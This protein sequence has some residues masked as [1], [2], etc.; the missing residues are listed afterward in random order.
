MILQNP[1]LDSQVDLTVPVYR[2]FDI[3]VLSLWW[4]DGILGILDILVR[5]KSDCCAGR[6]QLGVALHK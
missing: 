3:L 5:I 4:R 2:A 6:F 1:P